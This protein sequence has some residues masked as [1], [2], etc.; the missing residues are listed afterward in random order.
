MLNVR[1][2]LIIKDF[3]KTKEKEKSLKLFNDLGEKIFSE[4]MK[5]INNFLS[6]GVK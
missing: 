1:L 5:Q 2:S 6:N 3:M 4:T